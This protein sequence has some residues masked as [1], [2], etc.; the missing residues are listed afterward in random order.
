VESSGAGL[1]AGRHP[2]ARSAAPPAHEVGDG[3]GTRLRV[4]MGA[5][6][7]NIDGAEAPPVV[8]RGSVPALP[9][10][11]ACIEP[12]GR[13]A[14]SLIWISRGGRHGPPMVSADEKRGVSPF[15]L[16]DVFQDELTLNEEEQLNSTTTDAIFEAEDGQPFAPSPLRRSM[17][18]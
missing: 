12:G 1:R 9:E 3:S 15:R 11:D 4:A 17:H 7:W 2:E 16:A 14:K 18:P 13:W 5:S 6:P 10:R 8:V